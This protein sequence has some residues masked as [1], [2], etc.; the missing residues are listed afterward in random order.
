[1][2]KMWPEKLPLEVRNT[3]FR[4]AE[5]SVFDALERVLEDD[6][7]VF[8]SRPWLGEDRFGNERDGECDFL[9][10]HPRFGIFAI[11]VKGGG[12]AYDPSASQWVSTDRDGI[13]HRI[14]DPVSQAVSAKHEMLQRLKDHRQWPTRRIH[15]AHGVIF[16][17]AASPPSDLGADKPRRIFCCAKDLRHDLR[18][19]V[20]QR[21]GEGRE[22]TDDEPLGA[23]GIRALEDIL[24]KPVQL[25]FSLGAQIDDANRQLIALTPSQFHIIDMI[26]GI[27]KTLVEGGAGTGKTVIAIEEARRSALAGRKTLLTCF[28]RSLARS[29]QRMAGDVAN[30]DIFSFHSF[31]RHVVKL[32][33]HQLPGEDG[34]PE[35]FGKRLPEA[36]ML[37][38]ESDTSLRWDEIVV[39]EGQD[40]QQ[41]WWIILESALSDERR[42]RVFADS[43]QQVYGE[44]EAPPADLE[45]IP[46]RLSQNLRNTRNIHVAAAEHYSGFPITAI[47]PEGTLVEWLQVETDQPLPRVMAQKLKDLVNKQEWSP[48]GT[49]LLLPNSEMVE[50][51]RTL[52]GRTN[53]EV[54]D[55]DEMSDDAVVIDTVRRFKGLERPVVLIAFRAQDLGTSEYAYVGL[56]RA[57]SHL[58]IAGSGEVLKWLGRNE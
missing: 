41:L 40:F 27:P 4:K 11:E 43:N 36:A 38:V 55:A 49:A 18:A 29:M 57:S 6:F 13:R 44:L 16:P 7:V 23:D 24:A 26:S 58:V 34:S 42:M 31:C 14:K 12:I 53:M 51:T 19:W 2:A 35:Y 39:D 46:I 3:P 22:Q 52:V 47:G 48:S 54:T 32:A 50:E 30:L 56:S 10:A 15:I 5:I 20:G 8:Y 17:N 33:G 37:A 25:K 45:L 28:N 9:I 21:M 1:M